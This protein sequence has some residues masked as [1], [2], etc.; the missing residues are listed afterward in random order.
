[1][2]LNVIHGFG[3]GLSTY[4]CNLLETVLLWYVRNLL[5]LEMR[6]DML[7]SGRVMCPLLL[8]EFNQIWNPCTPY[9]FRVGFDEKSLRFYELYADGR[10]DRQT[11]MAQIIGAFLQRVIGSAKKRQH[12]KESRPTR[13]SCSRTPEHFH[14]TDFVFCIVGLW[15]R[16]Y[17]TISKQSVQV[18]VYFK[19]QFHVTLCIVY[20]F[21]LLVK[22]CVKQLNRRK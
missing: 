20:S 10:T 3:F 5:T 22:D 12:I 2:V 6:A 8:S 17:A 16:C 7:A 19:K 11:N 18:W 14:T 21:L 15:L 4:I 9:N 13:T 1:M